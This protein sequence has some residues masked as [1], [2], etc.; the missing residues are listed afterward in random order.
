MRVY[1]YEFY[2]CDEWVRESLKNNRKAIMKKHGL[3]SLTFSYS[4]SDKEPEMKT[5]KEDELSLAVL[6]TI[7][8]ILKV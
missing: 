5:L 8:Q 3:K 2:A 4:L 1:L 6:E 7:R